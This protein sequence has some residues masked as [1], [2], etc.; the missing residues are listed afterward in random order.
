MSD[1]RQPAP[2]TAEELFL[3]HEAGLG[4]FLAQLCRDRELA[5]DVLQETFLV[6]VQAG[7]AIDDIEH[8]RAWLYGVARR[9]ALHSLRSWRRMRHAYRRFASVPRREDAA[10]A[11]GILE[12]RDLLERTLSPDDRSLIILSALH[13]FSTA[14]LAEIAELRPE[15]VRKRLSRA[16]QR[17]LA[18]ARAKPSPPSP[19]VTAK[20]KE[21]P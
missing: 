4:R 19:A 6:V 21:V 1:L 12:L 9:K 17:L 3:R 18:A 8:S 10:E 7:P 5:A 2:S 14:E 15:A 20:P 16:R 11:L 13:G